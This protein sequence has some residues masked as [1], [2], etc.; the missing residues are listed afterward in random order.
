MLWGYFRFDG[1]WWHLVIRYGVWYFMFDG[2]WWHLVPT[3]GRLCPT[4]AA[5]QPLMDL[6]R[7]LRCIPLHFTLY[8][9]D[10]VLHKMCRKAKSSVKAST[11]VCNVLCS[12]LSNV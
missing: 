1:V 5:I 7:T 4:Q 10:K 2:A 12:S 3:T 6:G 9:F 11:I 8:Q